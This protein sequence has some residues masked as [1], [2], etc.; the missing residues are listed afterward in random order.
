MGML[1]RLCIW[2]SVGIV[3][4]FLGG[5]EKWAAKKNYTEKQLKAAQKLRRRAAFGLKYLTLLL[6]VLGFV[7]CV[8]FL[9]LGIAA[10]EQADALPQELVGSWVSAGNGDLIETMTLAQDGTISVQCTFRGKDTGTIRGVWH[11]DGQTLFTDI[12]EGT[13]PYQAE[14]IWTVDGR[15]LTLTDDSGTARYVRND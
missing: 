13:S 8:Y 9:I 15:E 12:Q 14:F 7:W 1:Y 6:L 2:L 5:G 10:P 4:G 11:A 3:L